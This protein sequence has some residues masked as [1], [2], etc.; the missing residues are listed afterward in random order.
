MNQKSSSYK[1]FGEVINLFCQ[2]YA[3]TIRLESEMTLSE[4]SYQTWLRSNTFSY[5]SNNGLLKRHIHYNFRLGFV[6]EEKL[7]EYERGQVVIPSCDLF[8]IAEIC[9]PSHSYYD[10]FDF[11]MFPQKAREL[12]I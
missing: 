1:F 10:Y 11:L 9:D 8:A 5:S 12:G 3:A 2:Y 4:L 7:A 6:T